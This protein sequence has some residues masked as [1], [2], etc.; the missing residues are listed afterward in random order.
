MTSSNKTVHLIP[1]LIIF[2]CAASSIKSWKAN[3]RGH[4]H[5]SKFYINV[6]CFWSHSIFWTSLPWLQCS[7]TFGIDDIEYLSQGLQWQ[8]NWKAISN[9]L[10]TQDP[11]A[12]E[13]SS[14]HCFT[15][16]AT[17]ASWEAHRAQ[18]E[19][20]SYFLTRCHGAKGLYC[21]PRLETWRHLSRS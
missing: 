1:L 8:R 5:F 2:K 9:C 18:N 4:G 10:I 13:T 17:V 12:R 3:F 6:S 21:S 14:L 20:R 15:A 7:Y 16:L 11:T 19:W